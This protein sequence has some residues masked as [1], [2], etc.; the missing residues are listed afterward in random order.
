M[1][2][3]KVING[4]LLKVFFVALI[5][6]Y[7]VDMAMRYQFRTA[8]LFALAAFVVLFFVKLEYAFYFIV[9]TRSLVDAYSDVGV[10]SVSLPI[11]V[12]GLISLLFVSYFAVCQYNVFNL[13]V[14]RIYGAFLLLCI[15]AVFFTHKGLVYGAGF[16][17]RLFTG[18]VVLN[19]T[20]LVVLS[21]GEDVYKKRIR[22]ISWSVLL[23]LI[24]PYGAFLY[25]FITGAYYLGAGYVRYSKFGGEMNLFSY[26]LMGALPFCLFFYSLTEKRPRKF[27]WLIFFAAYFYTIYINYTRNV[28]IGVF[29]L[30]LTWTILKRYFVVTY[31]IIGFVTLMFVLDPTVQ[32]RLK[33]IFI[34]LTSNK[35]FFELDPHLLSQR[36]LI[37]QK[38]LRYFIN[39]STF[40]E[41]LLGN[42]FD[43]RDILGA[44]RTGR[45]AIEHNNYLVLLMS[46]GIMGVSFYML[47]ILRL[48]RES[49]SLLRKTRES[50]FRNLAQIFI[51]FLVS[52]VIIGMGT[53]A[54]WKLTFQYFLSVFAG[55]VVAA[56][57]IEERK[58]TGNG[59]ARR[60]A[61]I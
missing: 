39:E 61:D 53:H 27:L 46:T 6:Y 40:I 23:S 12:G 38:N 55:L 16:W 1:L 17:F 26:Y 52:Y 11:M 21:A 49:F 34:I 7:F 33:D 9:V 47:Y 25:N 13:R 5:S 58:R 14:N 50:Y 37:W 2:M 42:G 54:I 22:L 56:N 51:A 59:H 30:I 48:F 36:I 35:G 44:T 29:F 41:K 10:G 45:R 31:A 3:E 8:A 4:R 32:D 43:I 24:P 18:F 19:L 15:P 57:I 60:E 20:V 28:W